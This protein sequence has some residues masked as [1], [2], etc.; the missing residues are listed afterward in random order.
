[1]NHFTDAG[2]RKMHST[3]RPGCWCLGAIAFPGDKSLSKVTFESDRPRDARP[4]QQL[5]RRHGG[6]ANLEKL[7]EVTG[8]VTRATKLSEVTGTV[9]RATFLSHGFR[10][11][12]ESRSDVAYVAQ[13]LRRLRF[14][15][16][17]AINPT[18]ATSDQRTAV[19]KNTKAGLSTYP[20]KYNA[21][22]LRFPP[23]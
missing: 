15:T 4:T 12:C 19:T 5:R 8:T 6:H 23:F 21:P 17:N 7:S 11:E 9:T 22:F 2:H 18:S 10:H 16:H 13:S 14:L 3:I 1:M 20:I